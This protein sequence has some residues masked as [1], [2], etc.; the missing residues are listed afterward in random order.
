VRPRSY[1]SG[2]KNYTR[3]RDGASDRDGKWDVRQLL[4]A[5]HRRQLVPGSTTGQ[6]E[7]VHG[8]ASDGTAIAGDPMS[9][10]RLRDRPQRATKLSVRFRDF[11]ML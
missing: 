5:V 10:T 6:V 1:T 11:E 4:R 2:R 8:D 3:L 7:R 9:S